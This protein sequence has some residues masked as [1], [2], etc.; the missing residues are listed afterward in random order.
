MKPGD[1]RLIYALPFT[2]IIDQTIAD[3]EDV[4]DA[5]STGEQ[6]TA[7]HYL[8]DT[9]TESETDGESYRD[10]QK[11]LLGETWRT[12]G[13]VTTFV[14]LFETLT[15]PTSQQSMKLPALEKRGDCCG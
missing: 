14:Q 5:D 4:F 11:A 7:H 15:G 1:G 9:I 13:T 3:L 6:L 10:G 2:S 12:G 8:E